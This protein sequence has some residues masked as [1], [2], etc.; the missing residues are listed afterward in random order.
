MLRDT[1]DP[2]QLGSSLNRSHTLSSN[3]VSSSGV[4]IKPPPISSSVPAPTAPD[5]RRLAF[6]FDSEG[7]LAKSDHQ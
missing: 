6:D 2:P 1:K 5:T 4:A 3:P 7:V